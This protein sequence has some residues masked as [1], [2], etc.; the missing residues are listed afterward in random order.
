VKAPL[1][2]RELAPSE[3]DDWDRLVVEAPEGSIHNTAPYLKAL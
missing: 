2:V 3:L 1:I